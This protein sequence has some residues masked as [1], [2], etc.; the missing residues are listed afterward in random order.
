M[1]TLV[2]GITAKSTNLLTCEFLPFFNPTWYLFPAFLNM[3]RRMQKY[4]LDIILRDLV[5]R[6]EAAL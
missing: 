5:Y 1:G 2:A 4:Y 6:K 3:G